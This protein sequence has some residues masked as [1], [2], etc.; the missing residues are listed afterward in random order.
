MSALESWLL[1]YL[2]NALWQ[3]P[4]VFAAGWV[5]ARLARHIGPS[6]EHRIWVGTLLLQVVLPFCRVR[7]GS[8]WMLAET[9]VSW[10]KPGGAGGGVRIL[11]GPGTTAGTA[12]LRL[13]HALVAAVAAGYV[14]CLLYFVGRLGWG[15][16]R[17]ATLRRQ[18]ECVVLNSDA[19]GLLERS[20]NVLGVDCDRVWIGSSPAVAGP[21]TL[22]IRSRTLLLPPN[23]IENGT[24]DDLHAALA[25]EL[26][27]IA[28]RDFAKN[29]IYEML[30]LPIAWH[31]VLWLTRSRVAETREIVCDAM[32]ADAVLGRESYAHALLRLARMQSDRIAPRTLHAIGIFD[33][34]IFERRIMNLSRGRL[35]R[36]G[37]R[38]AAIGAVCGLLAAGACTSALALRMDVA[39]PLGNS[40]ARAADSPPTKIH[41]KADQL[42]VVKKVIP[43]YPEKAKKDKDT[44]EGSVLLDVTIGTDG[45]PE[46][47]V[48]E[49]SLR[50]D[51]DTS[52]LEAVRQWQWQP[53]LLNGEP[54]KVETTITIVYS[55]AK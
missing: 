8:L 50:E 15:L 7:A 27:H 48:V 26:A 4:L 47:I 38:K 5:A 34:N 30:S 42:T 3:V 16:W 23:F 28:R 46:N 19:L 43:V 55:M 25:H 18:A 32:A 9:L 33:A 52:A 1:G 14:C 51:Y 12:V 2:L 53:Y 21:L 24:P 37:A 11:T 13:P 54:I 44:I 41:V 10:S 36:N 22:G 20:A 31:P 39:G 29:L 6:M 35:E 49:K 45:N 17:T 40:A